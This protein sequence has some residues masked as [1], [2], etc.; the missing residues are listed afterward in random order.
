MDDPLCRQGLKVNP[1]D[2]L[3]NFVRVEHWLIK[4]EDFQK[5]NVKEVRHALMDMCTG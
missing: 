5:M 4:N 2:S 3:T 1:T